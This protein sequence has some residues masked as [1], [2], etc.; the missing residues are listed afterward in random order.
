MG[1]N[2]Q[3]LSRHLRGLGR[4]L[5]RPAHPR[6][7][8]MPPRVSFVYPEIGAPSRYR[9]HH[10][11]EE[12]RIA[13]LLAQCTRL[14]DPERLYEL[15]A[16]DL[17]V[18]YR[19]SLGPRSLLLLA[20]AR[21]RR[22]ATA[23]DCDDL[24][25]DVRQ[26]EY[27]FLDQHYDSATVARL[28]QTARRTAALMRRVDGL[29]LSTPYLGTLAGAIAGRSVFVNLNAV[30]REMVAHSDASR[31]QGRPSDQALR[32]GYFSGQ[33][34]V[35]DE[36]LATVGPSLA[37]LLEQFPRL[38]ITLCGEVRVPSA[39][40]PYAA[41]I[42][43]RPAVDW[44][45]LPDEIAR[46]NI[47]I[48]PLVDNPQRRSKSAVKYLEAALCG[49]PS[50]AVRLEPY[51]AVVREGRTALLAANPRE[52]QAALTMLIESAALRRQLGE[53]ARAHVLAEHTTDA[54]A[55][56]FADIAERIVSQKKSVVS[57]PRSL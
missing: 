28:M 14:D 49:V 40:E 27:E 16:C 42:E 44:R 41:R 29:I 38:L 22:V 48:A 32:I 56:N 46:I 52:W 37:A 34:R 47:N 7:P 23:F 17:L 15:A 24:T 1:S 20:M 51:T 11:V 10:Q 36:D 19:T 35:H 53:A 13:G 57:S 54:R 30:S 3:M 45:T 5:L 21:L 43:R 2:M 39:L 6:Q 26:R 18:F 4:A 25:W 31:S 50:I 12:A 9:V 55:K 33:A 8:G